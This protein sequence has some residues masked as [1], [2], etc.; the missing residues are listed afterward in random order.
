MT[1]ILLRV[2]KSKKLGAKYYE[3]EDLR[4]AIDKREFYQKS[5]KF[6]VA[7]PNGKLDEVLSV[8]S[9]LGVKVPSDVVKQLNESSQQS[10]NRLAY[11]SNTNNVN[12]SRIIPEDVD[13]DVSLQI[14]NE[15]DSAIENI[16][17]TEQ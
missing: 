15:F 9:N 8:L 14:E 10:D 4:N 1:T 11:S 5:G 2:P 7:I 16:N 17:L 12:N 3:N 6:Q 13:K